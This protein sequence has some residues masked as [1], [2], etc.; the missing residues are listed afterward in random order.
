MTIGDQDKPW[1]P[2]VICGSCQST[3]EEWFRGTRR[4]MSFAIHRIWGEPT[5]QHNNYYFSMIDISKYKKI[6]EKY[7]LQYL[8]ILSSVAPV[9][10]DH[11]IPISETPPF[12]QVDVIIVFNFCLEELTVTTT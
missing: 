8:N 3:L 5:N 11:N 2:H 6:K 4:A 10:Y 7:A 9:P 12:L 1:A